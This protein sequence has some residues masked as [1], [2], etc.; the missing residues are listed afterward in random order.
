[1]KNLTN[2]TS[3]YLLALCA[4][5]LLLEAGCTASVA[6]STKGTGL[7]LL[8]ELAPADILSRYD[9]S[10]LVGLIDARK[11]A[12]Q[13]VTHVFPASGRSNWTGTNSWGQAQFMDTN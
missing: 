1:M 8:N 11:E 2:S 7:P 6:P 12:Y 10:N 3:A 13:I 4:L 9:L 5:A